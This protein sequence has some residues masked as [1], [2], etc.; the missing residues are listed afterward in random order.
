MHQRGSRPCPGSSSYRG[1]EPESKHRSSE[2][3]AP[4]QLTT[5]SWDPG[6]SLEVLCSEIQGKHRSVTA[7]SF[8]G[9][10]S[11]SG[12]VGSS[13]EGVIPGWQAASRPSVPRWEYS[14]HVDILSTRS[15][16]PHTYT[17]L[18]RP[19][20]GL[21]SRSIIRMAFW[22]SRAITKTGLYSPLLSKPTP[23][24]HFYTQ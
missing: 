6:Q 5:Q 24:P 14:N 18:L 4:R 9:A 12:C 8:M 17:F 13:W 23:P 16:L 10:G 22:R 1:G 11:L 19:R 3:T 20:P 2:A 21:S 7:S 15:L